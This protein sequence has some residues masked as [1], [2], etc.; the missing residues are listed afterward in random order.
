MRTIMIVDGD[1]EIFLTS[2]AVWVDNKEQ[3]IGAFKLDEP[4]GMFSGGE[5]VKDEKGRT[6]LFNAE[7][8]AIDAAKALY[9]K[10]KSA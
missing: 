7:Q 3:F 10:K 8:H 6:S 5:F 9:E 1:R 4:P 2:F